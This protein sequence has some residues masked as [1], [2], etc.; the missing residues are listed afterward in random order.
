MGI[1]TSVAKHSDAHEL[2]CAKEIVRILFER[3]GLS[4]IIR[5]PPAVIV[6]GGNWISFKADQALSLETV[7][8]LSHPSGKFAFV[9]DVLN[10]SEAVRSRTNPSLHLTNLSSGKNLIGHVDAHYWARNPIG[11][12]KEFL[13]KKTMAPSDL[14]KRLVSGP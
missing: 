6:G 13:E 7:L 12:A 11:H 5:T 2:D 10:R 8:G 3:T 4:P 14:L 9:S 1:R